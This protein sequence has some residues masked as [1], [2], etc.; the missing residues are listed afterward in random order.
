MPSLIPVKNVSLIS[1]FSDKPKYF[2]DKQVK[3]FNFQDTQAKYKVPFFYTGWKSMNASCD[4]SSRM[5]FEG[6]TEGLNIR[7]N[8]GVVILEE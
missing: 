4:A 2:S 8:Y 5:N 7:E 3:N 1:N 6:T